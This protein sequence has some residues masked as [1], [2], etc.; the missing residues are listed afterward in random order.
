HAA[1]VA[2]SVVRDRRAKEILRMA[3]EQGSDLG[4]LVPKYAG[5]L[6][7]ERGVAGSCGPALVRAARQA[8]SRSGGTMP[9]RSSLATSTA[10]SRDRTPSL[11]RMFF[12]CERTVS[13]ESTSVS[14][15][16]LVDRCRHRRS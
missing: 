7:H 3:V 5:E 4:E 15:M 13:L 12:T 16:S 14:A 8:A 11:R 10:C 2:D 1:Q 6:S 9:D